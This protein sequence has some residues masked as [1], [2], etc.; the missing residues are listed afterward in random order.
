MIK[1]M[2]WVYRA[3]FTIILLHANQ[4][5]A[6]EFKG[7]DAFE[8]AIEYEGQK[9]L[10]NS[11]EITSTGYDLLKLDITAKE[12]DSQDGFMFVITS[13]VLND[14]KG[15]VI[16]AFRALDNNGQSINEFT[17]LLLTDLEYKQLNDSITKLGQTVIPDVHL[18]QKFNTNII[19]E[20]KPQFDVMQY[21]FWINKNS[22]HS[23]SAQKWERAFKRYSKFV[24][25]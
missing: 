13:F 8:R 25:D 9:F 1:I 23:I 20:V 12:I 24:E 22:R 19:L 6:Q 5:I 4:L 16:T 7:F 3:F 11:F 21:V 10:L 2:I 15:I 17:N 14:E 18:I